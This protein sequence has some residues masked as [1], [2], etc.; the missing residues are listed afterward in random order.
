MDSSLSTGQRYTVF[1]NDKSIL[2]LEYI[3]TADIQPTDFCV[4]F[5]GKSG[6]QLEYERFTLLEDC[7]RLIFLTQDRFEEAVSAFNSL[8]K[9]VKAAGG[10]VKN[11]GQQIL[12]IFRLGVWDLPKGKLKK[13]E[14]PEEGA[15][16]EVEEETGLSSLQILKPLPS[17]FHIYTSRKGKAILKE[18]YWFEMYYDGNE[19]PVPQVEEDITEVKWFGKDE[20]HEVIDSTYTSLKELVRRYL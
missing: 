19:T 4:M 11:Q 20:L 13:K 7:T 9:D 6:M 2:I 12:G 17:T 16:R 8:F 14:I 10:I 18:T 15:I 5:Q 3:N 1:L